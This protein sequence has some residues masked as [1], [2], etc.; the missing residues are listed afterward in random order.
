MGNPGLEYVNTRHNVGFWFIDMLADKFKVSLHLEN[1]FF[2]QVGKFRF[3]DRDVWLLKPQTFM[4]LSGKAVLALTAFYKIS[5]GEVLVVHDELDFAPGAARLKLGGGSAG[6]NGLRSL[7]Q[8]VGRDFWRLRIGIGHP[9]DRVADFVLN[10]PRAEEELA[11][12]NALT[13]AM[14]VLKHFLSGERD[15]AIKE[16]HTQI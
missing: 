4:N 13:K 7:E 6:H 12:R 5:L 2:A 3:E 14:L 16:L 11:I 8:I 1:K 10:K 15:M 9:G